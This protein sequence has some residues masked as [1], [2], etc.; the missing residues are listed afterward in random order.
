MLG[1]AGGEPVVVAEGLPMHFGTTGSETRRALGLVL[2]DATKPD[3]IPAP[4][5]SSKGLCKS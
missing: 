5:W 3:V 2:Y 4:D 1:R